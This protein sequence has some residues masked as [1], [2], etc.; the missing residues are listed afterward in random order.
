[1][2]EA[3][4]T[5]EAARQ[6]IAGLPMPSL[7]MMASEIEQQINDRTLTRGQR[8]YVRRLLDPYRKAIAAELEERSRAA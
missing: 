5:L 4:V 7:T 3:T 8:V 2:S 6:D 1:M